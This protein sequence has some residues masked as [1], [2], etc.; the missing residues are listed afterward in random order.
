M[1]LFAARRSFTD[2]S[3]PPSYRRGKQVPDPVPDA[4][5]RRFTLVAALA[6]SAC[7]GG[8]AAPKADPNRARYEADKARCESIS[9]LEPARKSCMTYRGW[10]DGKYR[11]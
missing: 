5:M 9:S 4:D 7:G 2:R 3:G 6:L 11:R 10:P 8:D 1:P